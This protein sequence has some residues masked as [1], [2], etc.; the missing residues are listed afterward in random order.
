MGCKSLTLLIYRYEAMFSLFVESFNK[1]VSE[2]LV[3][4]YLIIIACPSAL[5]LKGIEHIKARVDKAYST[6]A[7]SRAGLQSHRLTETHV[8]SDH[9]LQCFMS[10]MGTELRSW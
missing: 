5:L 3:P 2:G 4:S 10:N 6:E 8:A 1:L 7:R 9:E